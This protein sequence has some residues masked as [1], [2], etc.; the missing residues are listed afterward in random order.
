MPT[1]R[2]GSFQQFIQDRLAEAEEV[3]IPPDMEEGSEVG[4]VILNIIKNHIHNCR[5]FDY[6]PAPD[7][8]NGNE[9]MPDEVTEDDDDDPEDSSELY[10]GEWLFV[11]TV[12]ESTCGKEVFIKLNGLMSFVTSENANGNT[13]YKMTRKEVSDWLKK[14]VDITIGRHL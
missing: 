3:E 12:P 2:K 5:D 1:A 4:A 8:G 13:E 10:P 11:E 14:M 7:S 9:L 6:R